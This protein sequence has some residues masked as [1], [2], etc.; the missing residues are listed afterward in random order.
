[1]LRRRGRKN[2]SSIGRQV[3]KPHCIHVRIIVRHSLQRD[4]SG[5]RVTTDQKVQHVS[6]CIRLGLGLG[7]LVVGIASEISAA[8]AKETRRYRRHRRGHPGHRHA[9]YVAAGPQILLDEEYSYE[10]K[11][12]TPNHQVLEHICHRTAWYSNMV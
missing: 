6:S 7:W 3:N 12:Q 5:H 4:P 2:R 8:A 11:E 9:L 10:G 1:M